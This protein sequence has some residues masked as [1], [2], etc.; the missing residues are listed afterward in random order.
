MGTS[1]SWWKHESRTLLN[2]VSALIKEV[3]PSTMWGHGEKWA[4]CSPKAALHQTPIVLV[5]EPGRPASTTVRNSLLVFRSHWSVAFCYSSQNRLRHYHSTCHN[6]SCSGLG[7]C[8]CTSLT[9]VQARRGWG[10][11]H[12]AAQQPSK[13]LSQTCDRI[14]S[15]SGMPDRASGW[16]V[17]PSRHMPRAQL[18]KML[19]LYSSVLKSPQMTL[20]HSPWWNPWY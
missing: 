9:A 6:A 4:A 16:L 3:S 15:L 18:L 5:P 10:R 20:K 13:K 2:G 17:R 11:D 19:S 8:T 14:Q 1:G 7:V 12:S